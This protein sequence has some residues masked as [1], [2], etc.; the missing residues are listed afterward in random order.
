MDET[1][2]KRDS[3]GAVPALLG[4]DGPPAWFVEAM[5]EGVK[6]LCRLPFN[7]R[8]RPAQMPEH[9]EQLQMAEAFA[10]VAW[11]GR[12]WN[13]AT[14]H[15][16]LMIGFRLLANGHRKFGTR[17]VD[18]F[19]NIHDLLDAVP[20]KQDE[21]E[22]DR[23]RVLTPEE[24]DRAAAVKRRVLNLYTPDPN[25]RKSRMERLEEVNRNLR[26]AGAPPFRNET[27]IRK[28]QR[29]QEVAGELIANIKLR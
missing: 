20:R 11:E 19:P 26:A 14:D 2:V 15:T 12:V 23:N 16:R 13:E 25:A 24:Q 10:E 6:D 7:K 17:T 27:E 8:P 29:R 1:P 4:R 22:A 21:M 3:L 28:H 18:D 5:Y 9:N